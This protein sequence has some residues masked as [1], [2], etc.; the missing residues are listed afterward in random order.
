MTIETVGG[1]RYL[2]A[3]AM[4]RASLARSRPAGQSR[5][6]PMR[7]RERDFAAADAN[8]FEHIVWPVQKLEPGGPPAQPSLQPAKWLRP[9]RDLARGKG[10]RVVGHDGL[11]SAQ[12][13]RRE[14]P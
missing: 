14:R 6:A 8:V 12:I 11:H 1:A 10:D 9:N 4:D 5:P 2:L 13:A 7:C 3:A